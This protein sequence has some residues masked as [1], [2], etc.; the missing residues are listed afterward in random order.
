MQRDLVRAAG[1][2]PAEQWLDQAVGHLVAEPVTDERPD[3][4]VGLQRRQRVAGRLVLDPRERVLGERARRPHCVQV[5]GDAQH[6]P[7]RQRVQRAACAHV[8]RRRER[9][10]L[11]QAEVADERHPFRT[12]GQHR[13]GADVHLDAGD[14]VGAQLPADPVGRLED[15]HLLA[16]RARAHHA[17]DSPAD[18]RRRRRRPS[19]QRVDQLD[20]A[21]EDVRIGV[22]RHAVTEVEDVAGGPA[23][24]CDD[25][26][27]G[28]VDHRPVGLQQR[29]IQVA[30]DDG[31]RPEPPRRLVERHPPVD[32]DDVRARRAASARAARPCPTPKW[33]RGTVSP[34]STARLCGRANRS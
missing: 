32:A 9:R 34:S 28:V 14:R 23:P 27:H 17:A 21:G 2:D 15:E 25:S 22:R 6:R 7:G 26:A 16:A 12:P 19:W 18:A 31:A 33:M 11:R 4:D 3:G 20:D 1:V 29:R 24:L 8:S 13:L 5:G 10:D 30:L